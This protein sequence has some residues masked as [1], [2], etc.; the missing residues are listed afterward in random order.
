MLGTSGTVSAPVQG[1][2]VE[3]VVVGYGHDTPFRVNGALARRHV[4]STTNQSH[5]ETRNHAGFSANQPWAAA[6][7][8]AV[9]SK[10]PKGAINGRQESPLPLVI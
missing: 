3:G 5:S 10:S 4:V 7:E 2:E 6:S 1:W 9:T 8:K